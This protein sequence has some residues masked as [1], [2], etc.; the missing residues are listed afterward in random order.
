[1]PIVLSGLLVAI[2]M[3]GLSVL[4]D[5]YFYGKLT[6]PQYNFV[7]LNV[8]DNLSKNFGV[9]TASYYFQE[10]KHFIAE[11]KGFFKLIIFGM[12]LLTT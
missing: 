2:P 1:M 5:S 4:I 7:Y 3:T 10:L 11:E 6:V 9:S 12:C 8:V